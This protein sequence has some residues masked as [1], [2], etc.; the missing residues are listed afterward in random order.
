MIG[1]IAAPS[2][3]ERYYWEMHE[4]FPDMKP[5]ESLLAKNTLTKLIIIGYWY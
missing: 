1:Q 2:S 4:M 3:D 5:L